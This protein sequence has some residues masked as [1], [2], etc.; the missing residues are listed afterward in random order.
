VDPDPA[1][2][3]EAV[4]RL[5][6]NRGLAASLGN[7]GRELAAAISWDAVIERLLSHG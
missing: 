4:A 6:A 1:A 5:D 2:I 3:A 7:N